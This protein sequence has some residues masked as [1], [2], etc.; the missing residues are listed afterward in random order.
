MSALSGLKLHLWCVIVSPA[1]ENT[2]SAGTEVAGTHNK[3]FAREA[4]EG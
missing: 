4:K 1:I 3:H 2:L